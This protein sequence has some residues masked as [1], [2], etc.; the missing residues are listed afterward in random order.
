MLE[1]SCW[2]ILVASIA[3][4]LGE[5]ALA[6]GEDAPLAVALAGADSELAPNM[7]FLASWYARSLSLSDFF[8][9][10]RAAWL[11]ELEEPGLLVGRFRIFR[12]GTNAAGGG[13]IDVEELA[14]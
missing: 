2:V 13:G 12:D 5:S 3:D 8:C 1:A 6:F 4:T 7:R 10:S 14:S 11:F 9:K